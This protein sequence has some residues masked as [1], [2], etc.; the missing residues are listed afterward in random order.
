MVTM[1]KRIQIWDLPT[2]LFHWSLVAAVFY[3]WFSV[4]ILEDMQQHFYSGYAVLTLLLFRIAW[5]FFG[6]HYSRF[7]TML[8][9]PK[10]ILD[11]LNNFRV[12]DSKPYC[13][14]N[15]LGSLSAILMILVLFAQTLLGLFS[16]DDYFFGPLTGLVNN[17]MIASAS[18]L[19]SLNKDLIYVL[20]GLHLAAIVYYQLRKKQNLTKAMITGSKPSP[21]SVEYADVS[22]VKLANKLLP[23][24]IALLC[25][26]VVY[27][28]ATAFLDR[29]PTPTETFY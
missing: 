4:E 18:E 23:L 25:I 7:S 8:F 2:R 10:D 6:S 1:K 26:A 15:P 24:V 17:D 21:D 5:G 28:L 3:S 19:H 20:I 9:S 11:Y 16:S 29:L 22:D 13:G 14:H 12:S 27:W